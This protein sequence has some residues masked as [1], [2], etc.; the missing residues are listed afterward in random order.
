MT[1]FT[2]PFI[3]LKPEKG[4][5]FGGNLPVWA[6]IRSIPPEESPLGGTILGIGRGVVEGWVPERD[7]K[8]VEGFILV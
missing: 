2:Y 3:H 4:S 1:D 5:P 8:L 7:Y 6:I